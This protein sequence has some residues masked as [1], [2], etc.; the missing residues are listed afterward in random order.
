MSWELYLLFLNPGEPHDYYEE[1]FWNGGQA[2]F[3]GYGD[4]KD[5]VCVRYVVSPDKF[6]YRWEL[7]KTCTAAG[8]DLQMCELPMQVEK[9]PFISD[10]FSKNINIFSRIALVCVPAIFQKS[11]R[12][13]PSSLSG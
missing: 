9:A 7:I 5:P 10:N 3:N 11:D 12:T 13:N 4:I 6:Q 8:T 2:N 1:T